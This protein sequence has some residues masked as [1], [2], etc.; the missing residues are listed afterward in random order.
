VF[1]NASKV[2]D[3][4]LF[5]VRAQSEFKTKVVT[6]C[7]S[8]SWTKCLVSGSS[9][10][11]ISIFHLPNLPNCQAGVQW[12][13]LRTYVC[14]ETCVSSSSTHLVT[15]NR[16]SLRTRRIAFDIWPYQATA[17]QIS[18]QSFEASALTGLTCQSKGA[19]SLEKS[20]RH[21][22]TQR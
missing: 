16:V 22:G 11:L 18:D 17:R 10:T 4:V 2:R 1:L 21:L 12:T 15:A 8:A 6:Q 3:G 7:E 5:R 14:P 13:S 20:H 19:P 9:T